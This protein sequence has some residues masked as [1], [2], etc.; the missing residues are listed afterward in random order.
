MGN[1]SKLRLL[2]G[3]GNRLID[4]QICRTPEKAATP[5]L[6]APA[7]EI[8]PRWSPPSRERAA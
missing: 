3:N 7:M 4:M 2:N 5:S 8:M 6:T 1:G